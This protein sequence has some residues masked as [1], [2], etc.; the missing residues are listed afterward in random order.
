MSRTT[1]A[2]VALPIFLA[3]IYSTLAVARVVSNYLRDANLLRLTVL[4][5]FVLAAVAVALVVVRTPA[6]R[7]WKV[8]LAFALAACAYAGAIYPMNRP[9]VMLHF[10]EYGVV[11]LLAAAAA[12]RRLGPR[13]RFLAAAVFT[14]AAGWLDEGIQALLPSRYYDLRDVAFNAAAGLFALA[15]LAGVRYAA[16]RAGP[17]KGCDSSL[18][19]GV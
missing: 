4:A 17:P 5:S 16:A 13:S 3:A 10:I 6:L 11:A 18:H 19:P 15:T 14:L 9:E 1:A 2:R 8:G 7:G 12:P